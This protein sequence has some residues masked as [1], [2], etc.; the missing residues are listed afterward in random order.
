MKREE[1]KI[2]M[3]VYFGRENGEET[4]GEIVKINPKKFK[5]KT[6]ES[7]GV[8]KNHAIGTIWTVPPSLCTPE[9]DVIECSKEMFGLVDVTDMLKDALT[10]NKPKLFKPMLT[11]NQ[12]PRRAS[13][14]F[15]LDQI[16]LACD[17]ATGDDG[18]TG[19]RVAETLVG[20]RQRGEIE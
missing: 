20:L 18:H 8:R 10:D 9:S 2:G 7:R 4:L 11:Q 1:G 3:R 6:L 17:I 16:Q 19:I 13:T 5:V 14:T 15:S 12:L